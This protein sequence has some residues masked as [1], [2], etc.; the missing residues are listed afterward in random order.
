MW[1]CSADT[2]QQWSYNNGVIQNGGTLLSPDC[3]FF[4][5]G[6]FFIYSVLG[7][8]LT[9]S[10]GAEIWAGKLADGSYAVGLF[11]RASVSQYISVDWANIL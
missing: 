1:N 8:C 10:G 4:G 11:N 7:Q 6:K 9:V 3:N 5:V 2:A